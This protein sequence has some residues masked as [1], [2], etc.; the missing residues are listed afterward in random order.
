[1]FV[2]FGVVQL[3]ANQFG[4]DRD[5][6]RVFVLS[7]ARRRDILMGKNL[8]F[9]PLVLGMA[10]IVLV[11]LQAVCPMRWDH[12]LAMIPQYHLDVSPVLLADE[13]SFDLRAGP[14]RRGIAQALEPEAAYRSL[15]YGHVHD[16]LSAHAGSDARFRW[17]P[18]SSCDS[19]AKARAC[20]FV[21]CFRCWNAR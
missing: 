17:A 7:A 4:F 3:M 13:F 5:G 1:M 8:S 9:A 20:R 15:A 6:F 16:F 19:L 2:L 21:C 12:F 18:N 14:R 10:A 11:T